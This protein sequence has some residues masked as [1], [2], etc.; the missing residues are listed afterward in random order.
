MRMFGARSTVDP[1]R[2]PIHLR[3]W[4]HGRGSSACRRGPGKVRPWSP[5]A[6]DGPPTSHRRALRNNVLKMLHLR[7]FCSTLA[8]TMPTLV[9]Y[10]SEL[11]LCGRLKIR[12]VAH[13]EAARD[14]HRYGA[15][16]PFAGE[17]TS[18][19]RHDCVC[20]AQQGVDAAHHRRKEQERRVREKHYVFY[21]R[22]PTFYLSSV[23]RLPSEKVAQ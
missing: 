20:L 15:G 11:S 18:C 5:R 14:E 2:R 21:P 7:R 9:A 1:N 22:R 6:W 17:G 19:G 4:R 13:R 23:K 16:D 10:P 12:F 3:P 8:C